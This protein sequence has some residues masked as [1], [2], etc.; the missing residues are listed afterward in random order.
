[1]ALTL[2]RRPAFTASRQFMFWNLFGILD[3]VVAVSTGVL[4]SGLVAGLVGKV[5]TAPMAQLPLVLI[6]AYLV[7]LFGTLSNTSKHLTRLTGFGELPRLMTDALRLN[8]VTEKWHCKATQHRR[9][10]MAD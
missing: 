4:G 1:V 6:P 8:V 7:P 5:T 9:I 10:G 3:L 2:V